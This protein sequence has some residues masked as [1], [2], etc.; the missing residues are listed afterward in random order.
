MLTRR[1]VDLLHPV[2]EAVVETLYPRRCGGCGRRGAWVCPDCDLA[3]R[4]FT[5]PWCER[6]GAPLALI[7]CRCAELTPA[8]AVV[9]S[10]APDDGWL[11]VAVRSFKYAGETARAGHLGALLLPVLAG[12]DPIDALVPVPL[13]PRRERKRGYNQARLLAAVAGRSAGIPVVEALVRTRPTAQQV[14][15]DAESRR[16]NVRGAFAIRDGAAIAGCRV[17]L[18]DDV[19]TTGS[20]L[21]NCAE[22]LVAGGAVWVGAATLARET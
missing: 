10:A 14:G 5:R 2:G 17:V 1:I 19:L 21:G 18:V 12:L 3:L 4:R 15:L 20:T 7:A 11:R 6:C 16:A 8:L 13:H 9:R 22:T